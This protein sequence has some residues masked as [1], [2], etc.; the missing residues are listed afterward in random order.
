VNCRGGVGQRIKIALRQEAE[1]RAVK[2]GG[3]G[4]QKLVRFNGEVT[5]FAALFSKE[6][7]PMRKRFAALALIVLLMGLTPLG[8][9]LS[10]DQ[11]WLT[12]PL[13]PT[14]STMLSLR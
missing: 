1:R 3:N 12:H 14:L 11:G 7:T 10:H 6:D 5:F 8:L 4:C 13:T 2:A 9:I